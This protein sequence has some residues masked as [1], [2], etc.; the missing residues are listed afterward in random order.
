AT[1]EGS[2]LWEPHRVSTSQYRAAKREPVT[3]FCNFNSTSQGQENGDEYLH[4]RTIG[5]LRGRTLLSRGYRN[6]CTC[7]I[8][9][10]GFRSLEVD[11]QRENGGGRGDPLGS[12]RAGCL[13]TPKC[14]ER[15]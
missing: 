5:L 8:R 15:K 3:N 4:S 14:G 10:R 7:R 11:R 12:S 6:S 1:H 13:A 9:S 2:I